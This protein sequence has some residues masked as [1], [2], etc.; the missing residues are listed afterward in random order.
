MKNSL[1][2]KCE[3]NAITIKIYGEIGDNFWEKY[4]KEILGEERDPEVVQNLDELNALLKANANA[5]TID[6]YINSN[7]GSVFDGIAMMNCIKRHKGYKRVH[8]DGFACSIASVIAMCGNQII[9]PKTSMMM[10]H[11]A[12]TVAMGNS[13]ELRK[14]ADDLDKINETIKNAYRSKIN[15]SDEELDRLMNEES[16]LSA[17][18]CLAMGFC[19]KVVDDNEDTQENLENA[20]DKVTSL[21]QN[22]LDTL[23]AIQ[24]CIKDIE[25]NVE[26]TEV[27]EIADETGE[28][29][30]ETSIEPVEEGAT[31]EQVEEEATDTPVEAIIETK[32]DGI[33]NDVKTQVQEAKENAL[34]RFFNLTEEN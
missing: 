13:Q 15:I 3:G 28:Q 12:W 9:M 27:V 7:G 25:N 29:V 20:L 34:K 32:E 30:E 33:E 24:K 23:N 10:I 1:N 19:T 26:P 21:F 31:E 6:I 22:K 11:N 4:E 2:F 17:D 5:A 8:I 16:Y 14:Q 18:E